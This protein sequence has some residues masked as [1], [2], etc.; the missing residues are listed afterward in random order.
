M[1]RSV[2]VDAQLRAHRQPRLQPTAGPG[3]AWPPQ[4]LWACRLPIFE[5]FAKNLLLLFLGQQVDQG[6]V[7]FESQP[8]LAY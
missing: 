1:F 2:L 6:S 7:D 3:C 4:A 8:Q 5:R